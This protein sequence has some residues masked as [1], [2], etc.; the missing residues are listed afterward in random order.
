MRDSAQIF[1]IRIRARR[2]QGL[3][4][5]NI[6]KKWACL[7]VSFFRWGSLIPLKVT[8]QGWAG[9][10]KSKLALC[11]WAFPPIGLMYH[12]LIC[13]L[14]Y[15]RAVKLSDVYSLRQQSR[16]TCHQKTGSNTIM[17]IC[18]KLRR[19]L[20]FSVTFYPLTSHTFHKTG[21]VFRLLI[22]SKS[23]SFLVILR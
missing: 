5:T 16:E 11:L 20:L 7:S 18:K 19:I 21:K 2:H 13:Q 4:D 3:A 23:S 12:F 9:L 22:N 15:L 8:F 6:L 14:T 1:F 17:N 10:L